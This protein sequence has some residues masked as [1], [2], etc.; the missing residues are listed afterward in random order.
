MAALV[1]FSSMK[2][3]GPFEE[4]L[5][6]RA[7]WIICL[8]AAASVINIT[9]MDPVA[10]PVLD[11]NSLDVV[12]PV[13]S[14]ADS[15]PK[16]SKA[17]QPKAEQPAPQ[18]TVEQ[19]KAEPSTAEQA[20]AEQPAANPD[21]EQVVDAASTQTAIPADAPK[22]DASKSDASKPNASKPDP[23]AQA[24]SDTVEKSDPAPARR[25]ARH[26]SR[27]AAAEPA[28]PKKPRQR[29]RVR[30]EEA[31]KNA[32][33]EETVRNAVPAETAQDPACTDG[34]SLL[35]AFNLAPACRQ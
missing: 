24:K 14:S 15:E 28:S 21:A 34:N 18:Q 9:T 27:V 22:V 13:V 25:S 10:M 12:T 3:M 11:V 7:I 16:Q 1:P 29:A 2:V 4:W 30:D 31:M 35:R 5:M 6:M 26:H 17:E 19:P 32:H 23:A 33:A 20:T 8:A